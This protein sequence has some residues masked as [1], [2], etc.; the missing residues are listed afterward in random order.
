MDE[1]TLHRYRASDRAEVFDFVRAMFSADDSARILAQWA[2]K[3]DSNPFNRP[4]GPTVYLVRVGSKLVSQIAAFRLPMWIAG[5]QCMAEHRGEQVVHPDY[6]RQKLWQRVKLRHSSDTP[7]AFAWAGEI[8][9]RSAM[10]GGWLPGP[11]TPLIRV[12][13]AGPLIERFTHSRLLGS[14]GTGAST[15][16]RLAGAPMRRWRSSQLGVRVRLDA[17]DDS[18]DALWARARR[19]DK[20]MVVRDHR[21][22]NWRYCKRPDASYML[23]GIKRQSELTG[24]LVAR[25]TTTRGVRTGHLVDFLV[26]EGSS[27]VLSVLIDDALDEFQANG[28]AAV[29]CYATDPGA[30]N[31]LFRHGFIPLRPRNPTHFIRRIRRDRAD[32][33]KYASLRHWYL[34]MGDGDSEM[35]M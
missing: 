14:I 24:F 9:T 4:E 18:V 8:S 34:T 2:W 10:G 27:D 19:T 20:A 1:P 26:A 15:A 22:L 6:R 12:L 28:V 21:Y 17:F 5:I 32:L 35:S 11:M 23:F 3:Y 30:R 7:I 16:A 33:Q 25:A 29:R 13:D 31:A